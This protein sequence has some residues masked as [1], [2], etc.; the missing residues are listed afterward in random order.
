VRGAS[1]IEM[2]SRRQQQQFDSLRRGFA[3]MEAGH[4]IPHREMRAWLLSLGTNRELPPP[5]CVCG[6]THDSRGEV[7]EW[8]GGPLG[9]PKARGVGEGL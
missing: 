3:E 8:K 9:P 5:K 7:R 2:R 6:E 4:Y 1:E